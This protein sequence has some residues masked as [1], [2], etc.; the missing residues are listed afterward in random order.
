MP[1][2]GA[3]Y[4]T[5]KPSF[6]IMSRASVPATFAMFAR[7]SP[8]S[9]LSPASASRTAA[10]RLKRAAWHDRA[11]TSTTL[12]CVFFMTCDLG[13]VHDT[14][15]SVLVFPTTPLD[16]FHWVTP[17]SATTRPLQFTYNRLHGFGLQR[18]YTSHEHDEALCGSS[19][20]QSQRKRSRMHCFREVSKARQCWR[21]MLAPTVFSL[22]IL[23]PLS[24]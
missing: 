10:L 14:S 15:Q 12:S 21:R 20:R 13:R 19:R 22:G 24:E 5:Q 11:S 8:S 16:W 6:V 17:L 23:L 2:H 4:T 9:S 1:A 3:N 7:G 18:A